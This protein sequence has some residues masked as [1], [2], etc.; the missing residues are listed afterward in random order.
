MKSLEKINTLLNFTI[1]PNPKYNSGRLVVQ[2]GGRP[3]LCLINY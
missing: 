2:Y 1:P 3:F